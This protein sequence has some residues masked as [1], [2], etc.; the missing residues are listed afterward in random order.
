MGRRLP[1]I[2]LWFPSLS[3]SLVLHVPRFTPSDANDLFYSSISH[4]MFQVHFLDGALTSLVLFFP[5][6]SGN[7]IPE[8]YHCCWGAFSLS[9]CVFVLLSVG[10]GDKFGAQWPA[11]SAMCHILHEAICFIVV[12]RATLSA[13]GNVAKSTLGCFRENGGSTAWCEKISPLFEIP[14]SFLP[15]KMA[16]PCTANWP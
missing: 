16:S 6:S 15:S 7:W 1:F 3:L 5:S 11:M 9:I 14:A 4:L 10:K 12:D 13:R 2:H 8:R